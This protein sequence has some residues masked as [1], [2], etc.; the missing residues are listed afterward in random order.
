MSKYYSLNFNGATRSLRWWPLFDAKARTQHRAEN[1]VEECNSIGNPNLVAGVT[2]IY[3]SPGNVF[4]A[5]IS[6]EIRV[7]P[8]T[9]H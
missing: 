4:P 7:S 8:H 2:V 1:V 5:H 9:Y 6:L 3:V